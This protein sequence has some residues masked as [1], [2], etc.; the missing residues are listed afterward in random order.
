[1][2]KPFKS[3]SHFAR[4]QWLT[5]VILATGKAGIRRI[6]VQGQPRQEVH[7]TPVLTNSWTWWHEPVIPATQEAKIGRIH[8]SRPAWTKIICIRLV[9][10]EML[11]MAACACHP[12][13]DKKLKVLVSQSRLACAKSKT[14]SPK[15]PE[16]KK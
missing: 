11:S 7:E 16:E 3:F 8:G 1:V 2:S 15:Y 13:V 4:S 12:Q 6:S 5:S 10:G 9:V 14:L